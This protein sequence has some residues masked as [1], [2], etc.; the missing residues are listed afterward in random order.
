MNLLKP[1]LLLVICGIV[2]IPFNSLSAQ[3]TDPQ[4]LALQARDKLTQFCAGCHKGKDSKGGRFNARSYESLIKSEDAENEPVVLPGKFA[5]SPLWQAIE[6]GEMPQEGSPEQQTFT[7]ADKNVIRTWIEKGAPAWPAEEKADPRP[8]ISVSQILETIRDD[9]RKSP[10][11]DRPYQ[12]Y[13]TITHLHNEPREKVPDSDLRLYRA[14]LSKAANSLSWKQRIVVPRG[15]DKDQTVF[16]IDL[17]DLDW[18][19]HELWKYVVACYPYGLTYDTHGDP[20]Y[21]D[22]YVEIV[23]LSGTRL[24]YIRA[25][26]FV[27]TATRPPLYHALLQL[28][29]NARELEAKLGVDVPQNFLR[30]RLHRAGFARSKV[31]PQANRL[32]ERHDA[33]YGAYWKSYDFIGGSDRSLLTQYPLG[34]V[35]PANPYPDQA[36]KHAGGEIIFNLPNGLQAYLLVDGMDDRINA[37]PTEIVSDPQQ[38]SGS[39]AVINGISCMA[40]H[41]EGMKTDFKDE[42]RIGSRVAGGAQLKVRDLYPEHKKMIQLLQEDRKKFL[43][44]QTKAVGEF[45]QIGDDANK[46]IEAFP[47]PIERINRYYRLDRLDAGAAA[48]ELGVQSAERLMGAIQGNS[49]L[50]TLGLGPLANG[51]N[52]NRADWEKIEGNSTFQKAARELDLGTP[53]RELVQGFSCDLNA[54]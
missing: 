9:L 46:P 43:D 22:P 45:L 47:E 28:P 5:E 24:P 50:R 11:D 7:D 17:R 33:T 38:T 20:A 2:W 40:C 13:Y 35:F 36:F 31:S 18:D 32:V 49:L 48:A 42:I 1:H 19:R 53:Y 29:H 6:S 8:Y 26:W 27:A 54:K 23:A 25:D 41:N 34:P 14:A 39:A 44:A 16:A 37:A 10:V 21:R 4:K 3:E 52:I 12:R 15:V 30:K 51:G